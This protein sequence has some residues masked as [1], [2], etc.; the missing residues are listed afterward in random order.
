MCEKIQKRFPTIGWWD[1][2]TVSQVYTALEEF[3]ET[4]YDISEVE[5]THEV[6]TKYMYFVP[7]SDQSQ[8]PA[9]DGAPPCLHL[10]TEYHPLQTTRL[11][12]GPFLIGEAGLVE[13]HRPAF[14]FGFVSIGGDRPVYGMIHPD[15]VLRPK[16]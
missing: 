2:L 4:V 14:C 7:M 9:V 11:V 5:F 13:D 16:R 6:L 10:P 3:S 15:L 8:L 1:D 12:E